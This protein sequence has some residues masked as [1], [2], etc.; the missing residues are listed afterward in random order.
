VEVKRRE[1]KGGWWQTISALYYSPPNFLPRDHKH[2][3]NHNTL[4]I[5][6]P[7]Y[8]TLSIVPLLL[9]GDAWLLKRRLTFFTIVNRFLVSLSCVLLDNSALSHLIT[10]FM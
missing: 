5:T 8:P 2:G 6:A 9:R 10:A 7:Q 1:K 3:N 4:P